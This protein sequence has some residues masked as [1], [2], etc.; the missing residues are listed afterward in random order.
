[1]WWNYNHGTITLGQVENLYYLKRNYSMI[2][3]MWNWYIYRFAPCTHCA[4]IFA[5]FIKL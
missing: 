4:P 1:M 2:V 5:P 3:S